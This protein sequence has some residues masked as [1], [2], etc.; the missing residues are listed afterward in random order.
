MLSIKRVLTI[1]GFALLIVVLGVVAFTS[2][3]TVDESEQAVMITLGEVEEGISEPGLHF[4]MPYQSNQL[5][6][7]LKK[8]S[9]YSLVMRNL[10][11]VK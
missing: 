6:F 9:V 4:K 7:Y 8:P 11:M 3:Y 1:F 5:K 10:R 2:W